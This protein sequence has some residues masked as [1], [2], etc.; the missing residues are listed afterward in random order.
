MYESIHKTLEQLNTR[1][2]ED[3]VAHCFAPE[4]LTDLCDE[5]DLDLYR[6]FC[7]TGTFTIIPSRWD[8]GFYAY[9]IES[10]RW[11]YIRGVRM[12]DRENH[13]YVTKYTAESAP[14]GG[15]PR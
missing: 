15:V 7:E 1:M 4:L 6:L 11:T 14:V 3:A 12:W 10:S 13:R 5:L 2:T 9:D 8:G